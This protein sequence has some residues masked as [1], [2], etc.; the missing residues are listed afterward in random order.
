MLAIIIPYFKIMFF[1]ANLKSLA[2]Q[3][4]KRFKVYIGNDASIENPEQLLKKYEG[5]FDFE[6]KKFETNLGSISL[7]EQWERCIAMSKNEEWLMILGDDDVLGNNLVASFYKNIDVVNK[8]S[9]NLIRFASQ[10]IDDSG[11][12]LSKVCYN[13]E[14][15]KTVDAYFKKFQWESRSSLSEYIFRRESY[16]AS[17]F[18]DF[19]LGWHSDDIAWL[20]F[21]NCGLMY[22]LNDAIVCIRKSKENISGKTD[23]LESKNRA[24]ILFLKSIITKKKYTF[25]K[26]QKTEFLFNYGML[27]KQEN[28]ININN[29]AMGFSEFLKMGSFYDGFRFLRR[30]YRARFL[31]K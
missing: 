30:M 20:D 19:P 23:N 3:T 9:I 18:T 1:E 28:K 13:P 31:R 12:Q 22:G 8:R 26:F 10:L 4:D 16:D 25:N 15:E 27:I 5:S 2:N 14:T 6:Y 21:T 11:K 29:V 24:T 17:G 7:T